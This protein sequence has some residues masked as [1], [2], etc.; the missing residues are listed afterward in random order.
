[1]NVDNVETQALDVMGVNVAEIPD[2][3]EP[4]S[5]PKL[6]SGEL[7]SQ[8]QDKGHQAEVPA[9]SPPVKNVVVPPAQ[10]ICQTDV[11][12]IVLFHVP[13]VWLYVLTQMPNIYFIYEAYDFKQKRTSMIIFTL[14]WLNH[15]KSCG[16]AALLRRLLPREMTMRRFCCAIPSFPRRRRKRPRARKGRNVEQERER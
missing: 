6:S 12:S 15:L 16:P 2:S 5:S 8:Y 1:V 11:H 9:P 10:A 7:R 13:H 14:L 3:L 4:T